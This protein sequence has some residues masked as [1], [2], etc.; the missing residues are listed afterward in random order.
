MRESEQHIE[1]I[2]KTLSRVD[3]GVFERRLQQKL[4]KTRSG[5][6][7]ANNNTYLISQLK[8]RK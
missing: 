4:T 3:R 5:L 8:S 6:S 1:R 7:V 2:K